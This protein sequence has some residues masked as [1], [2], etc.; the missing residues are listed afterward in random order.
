MVFAEYAQMWLESRAAEV[1]EG[2]W[3]LEATIIRAYMLPQLG[4]RQLRDL[5]PAEIAAWRD[6]LAARSEGHGGRAAAR[7]ALGLLKTMLAR[8]WREYGL[9]DTNPAAAVSLPRPQLGRPDSLSW[10]EFVALVRAAPTDH[11]LA[12]VVAGTLGPRWSEQF[13]LTPQD[14]MRSNG[15]LYLAIR[16]QGGRPGLKTPAADRLVPVW[17]WLGPYLERAASSTTGRLWPWTYQGWRRS[18]WLP[19]CR[20]AG[21]R[22]RWHELR[23]HAASLMI[24]LGTD[25][26]TVAAVLGHADPS[27]TLKVYTHA[28]RDYRLGYRMDPGEVAHEL[29]TLLDGGSWGG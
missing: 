12:L 7:R 25:V 22:R 11:R 20:A 9:V 2:T 14:V 27:V 28:M 6:R 23:H 24:Y 26:A 21:T 8:A 15:A 18:V 17:Q 5:K 16:R 1:S 4:D 29:C 13:A 10:Q 19:T 3:K